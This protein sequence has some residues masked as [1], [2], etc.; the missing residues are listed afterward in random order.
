MSAE[1]RANPGGQDVLVEFKDGIAWVTLNRPDKRN[2]MSPA[3]NHE[4]MEVLDALE[5]DDRC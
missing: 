4:M 5:I 1:Q 3:L 2:A